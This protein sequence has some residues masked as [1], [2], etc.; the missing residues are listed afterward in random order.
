MTHA[1][2]AALALITTAPQGPLLLCRQKGSPSFQES[3]RLTGR[4]L[5]RGTV[6][7]LD[8]LPAEVTR[9]AP[10][11]SALRFAGDDFS[12]Q[13]PWFYH[14]FAFDRA[15]RHDIWSFE[16]NGLD[17]PPGEYR[18]ALQPRA[19]GASVDVG[20]DGVRFE[21]APV[22]DGRVELG[23]LRIDNRMLSLY[24]KTPL[25][26]VYVWPAGTE[27]ARARDSAVEFKAY[28]RDIRLAEREILQEGSWGEFYGLLRREGFGRSDLRAMYDD[29]LAWCARRQVLDPNDRYY[30]A[31]YSEEDK[32]D[33]RDAAAAA[34]V[35]A[36]AWRDTKDP[37]WRRRALAARSYTYKGQHVD[38]PQN[39]QQ[40]GGFCQMVDGKWGLTFR[41]LGDTLP[42][43]TGV[44]T[45]IAVNHLVKTI[46]LG[47]EPSEEDLKRLELAGAWVAA[48]EFRPG[49]FHHHEGSDG[50]CQNSNALA[51]MA[52]AR[53][54]QAL[55]RAGR[56]PP[57]A[58][59][60]AARRGMAHYLDGQEAIGVWPY[61]FAT[62][63]RG[64]AFHERNIPDQGMG[65][66]HFLVACRT[67]A[68]RHEQRAA[69]RM[70]RAA[71]WWLSTSRI[72]RRDPR[73]T[74]DLDDRKASGALKFSAFTW[75][76]FTAAASLLRI[77][78]DSGE[79]EPWRWLALRYMEHVRLKLWN[80]S[81]PHTAPV[82]RATR[83]D[84]TLCSW[85]QAAEWDA[86]LL[87]D[88]EDSLLP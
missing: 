69:D 30:G 53:A 41:R 58:W 31:V 62:I 8:A 7:A 32:Y 81:D 15:R 76:R 28:R 39:P 37:Q 47:L 4:Q 21:P 24:T 84:M 9:P 45:C 66:Y 40:Y 22:R 80:R 82:R 57:A 10:K 86:A 48:N 59:L 19:R 16:A 33:F 55:E 60:E 29:L 54:H 5:A 49:V 12:S 11:A 75:C 52:L 20:F 85:I 36:R 79:T 14:G 64:Q 17:L 78:R 44:E 71:R 13:L 61:L 1:I 27:F 87:A 6:A 46:E 18:V 63:G 25:E 23:P 68:F 51:A 3:D 56:R 34:V 65:A 42:K 26:T 73:P 72:D 83:D 77:A 88:M 70:R 38:D 74:I 35:F 67:P 50:D 2:L 43:V